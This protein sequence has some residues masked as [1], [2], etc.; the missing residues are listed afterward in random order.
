[1]HIFSTNT[2]EATNNYVNLIILLS[3]LAPTGFYTC[4]I[5]HFLQ[6]KIPG[7]STEALAGE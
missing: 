6:P 7:F 4:I 3:L 5:G 2:A 1:M